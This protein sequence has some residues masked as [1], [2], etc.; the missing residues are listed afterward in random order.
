MNRVNRLKKLPQ[1]NIKAKKCYGHLGGKLGERIFNRLLE[2][3]W[4]RLENAKATVYEITEKG[5][6]ELKKLGVNLNQ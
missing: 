2:L 5:R 1:E 3:Q 4:F 6:K